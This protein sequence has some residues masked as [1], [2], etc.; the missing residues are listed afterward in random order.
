N[1][2]P[3]PQTNKTKENPPHHPKGLDQ[4]DVQVSQDHKAIS[5][6]AG[7]QVRAVNTAPGS[8]AAATAVDDAES[9]GGC[10]IV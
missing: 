6:I 4:R 3:N 2:A 10:R 8:V 9:D 7:D 1:S 5:H